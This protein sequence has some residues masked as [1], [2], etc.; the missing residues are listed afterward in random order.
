MKNETVIPIFFACDEPFMKYTCVALKSLICNASKEYRY[1]VHILC[2]GISEETKQKAY[3]LADDNF[4]IFFDDVSSELADMH[5][6][7]H[8]RDYYS[9]TTYFRIFIPDKFPQY[10][11]VIYIDS[12]TIIKGDISELYLMD[13]GKNYVGGAR[14]QVVLQLD[15]FGEYVEKVLGLPRE[16]YFNAGML[17]IN[18][19]AFRKNHI[20]DKFV[21]LL[22]T[23]AFVVAQDQDYLNVLCQN[24]VY[25][26]DARWN[27][28][29]CQ[30]IPC[31]EEDIRIIH[32]NLAAKPWHYTDCLYADYFW[33][34][35]KQTEDY[36]E[37]MYNLEHYTEEERH[38][39]IMAGEN[40]FQLATAEIENENNYMNLL[41][42]RLSQ[43]KE[44]QDIL[45]KIAQYERE[46][47]F[48]ED[49]E[50]DPPTIEL[51]PEDIH[52]VDKNIREKIRTKSA[53]KVARWFMNFLIKKKQLIIKEIRGIENIRGLKS[54]A[55]ITCNHFN[56]LDSF[57]IQA[58]YDESKQ[59]RKRKF[60]RVIR[61]GNYTNFP[62]FYGYLM[63]N[64]NTL[65]LSENH[66]TMKKFLE[67][68]D[69]L[70]TAGHFIL[71]YPEQSMWW[72]YKK[73]KPLKNGAF[74]FA[75][76]NNVP[77]LPCFITMED[78]DVLDGDGFYVQE[79]TI[80]VAPPIYPQEG[81]S[82]AENTEYM[83]E[84]NY[85]IWKQI[86]EETYQIPL[87]YTCQE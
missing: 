39:D 34:Y 11:K 7:L 64:C 15:L 73:P 9:V 5:S 24:K 81:K 67:A 49:V 53:F 47:R 83:K 56:A 70:L 57:A 12:D 51:L 23:Y 78:S 87:Q 6:R 69:E 75:A 17:V 55:I 32:Y 30:E 3:R 14:D 16:C 29:T 21:E 72:N 76:K 68:V 4:S 28:E 79:Y 20:L 59:C 35:A 26:L 22:N 63:R 1:H 77:V 13:I 50:E 2:T 25:W 74:K 27:A 43:S 65:P 58:V 52:Y 8:I 48:D 46:G 37:L 19:K 42:H 84:T 71:I 18:S 31:R 61:E 33:E 41:Q 80:H 44:R 40:L 54:G 60:Y 66:K 62:G 38:K 36:E 85:Q 86:Y 45:E 10:D 82:I